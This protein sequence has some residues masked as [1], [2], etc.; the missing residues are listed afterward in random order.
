MNSL[1]YRF[2][3]ECQPMDLTTPVLSEHIRVLCK[4]KY[5]PWHSD[6]VYRNFHAIPLP[7]KNAHVS[8][9]FRFWK[10]QNSGKS[11]SRV[12]SNTKF[13]QPS[14]KSPPSVLIL[15]WD[16]LSRLHSVRM[17]PHTRNFLQDI[18]AVEFMGFTKGIKEN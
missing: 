9:K 8:N 17:L 5:W 12:R 16:T 18:G 10:L 2:D 14:V 1:F 15:G 3:Q 11:P 4:S 6:I 13:A 7:N